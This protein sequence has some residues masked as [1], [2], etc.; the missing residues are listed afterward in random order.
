MQ[1]GDTYLVVSI[2]NAVITLLVIVSG[3]FVVK[4]GIGKAANEAQQSAITALQ[5]E[6]TAQRGRIDDLK[7]ENRRLNHTI[8]TVCTA[9][10]SKGIIITI[11]GEIVHISDHGGDTATRIQ[12]EWLR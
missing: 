10:K 1:L 12:E 11:S 8:D 6:L 3:L 7:V 9:L 4:G 2:L 5:S